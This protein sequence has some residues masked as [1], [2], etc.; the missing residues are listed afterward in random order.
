MPDTSLTI[1]CLPDGTPTDRLADDA[2]AA[3]FGTPL[4]SLGPAAHFA[5]STRR[6]ARLLQPWQDT[7]AGG[8]IHLL[9]LNA[10]RTAASH[11]AWYR[12]HCWQQVTT[13]TRPAQPYWTFVQ[14]HLDQPSR[15]SLARAQDDYRAQPRISCMLAHNGA[16]GP[17]WQLPTTNLEAFQ[18][19]LHGYV[20]Y[21]WL[22]A[23]PGEYLLHGEDTFLG[24]RGPHH[25]DRVASLTAANRFL[26]SLH[27]GV[28][29]VA[30][31]TR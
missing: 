21:G 27:R 22:S 17:A 2:A 9:D 18:T 31:C 12:W 26:D 16:A 23:V 1:V 28:V 6:R 3:L 24:L 5:V 8:P 10:M 4:T 20:S 15:Y 25:A 13:G 11:E 14:R 29:L 30:L 7:A 19:G